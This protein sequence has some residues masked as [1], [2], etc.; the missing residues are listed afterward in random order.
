MKRAEREA[1]TA[2][3]RLD[4]DVVVAGRQVAGHFDAVPSDPDG[5]PK[6]VVELGAVAPGTEAHQLAVEFE[7][8]RH[9]ECEIDVHGLHGA[10]ACRFDP[11]VDEFDTVPHREPV[12][13][14]ESCQRG[15]EHA[16]PAQEGALTEQG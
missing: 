14:G 6:V 4:R 5:G 3:V 10:A 1:G 7:S 13:V 11:G 16:F 15:V 8:R 12:P 2:R 9:L